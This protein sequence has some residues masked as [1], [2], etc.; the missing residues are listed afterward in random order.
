MKNSRSGRI[1]SVCCFVVS[2]IF[3]LWPQKTDSRLI[4]TV[5]PFVFFCSDITCYITLR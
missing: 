4:M 5:Y 3:R 2:D 1:V